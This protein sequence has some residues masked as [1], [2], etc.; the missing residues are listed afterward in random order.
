MRAAA[1]L[2]RTAESVFGRRFVVAWAVLLIALVATAA[3]QVPRSPLLAET[4]FAGAAAHR[5]RAADGR[6]VLALYVFSPPVGADKAPRPGIVFFHGSGW[7]EGWVEQFSGY[8]RALAA[9]GVVA[10]CADYRT[11]KSAGATPFDGVADARAAMRW[12]RSHAAELGLDPQRLAAAGAS[13]GAHLAL[14][15]AIFTGESDA[16]PS[17]RPD[18]LLLFSSVTDTTAEGY[19]AGVALFG[20]RE[21]ELS[22]RHHLR[23]GLPPMLLLHGAADAW[24]PLASAERFVR[25]AKAVGGRAELVVFAGRGHAFFNSVDYR[26]GVRADDFFTCLYLTEK[27]LAGLGWICE[28][29]GIGSAS[30]EISTP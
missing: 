27:F 16:G 7:I 4:A 30:P 24:V 3:A 15:A 6:T 9:R 18:A 10:V 8:A 29:V 17:A 21:R 11:Q 13:S 14:S 1:Y 23:P 28:P 20:G 2:H 12:L 5:F 19:P 26:P 25:E 22:P